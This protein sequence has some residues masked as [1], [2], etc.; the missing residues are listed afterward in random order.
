MPETKAPL[1]R[2]W[3]LWVASDSADNPLKPYA[4]QEKALGCHGMA[5]LFEQPR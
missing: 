1:E 3:R 2:K 4:F 5:I